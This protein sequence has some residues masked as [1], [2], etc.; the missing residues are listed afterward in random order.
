MDKFLDK[1]IYDKAKKIADDKYKKNSAYKS[2][3]M[4]EKYKELGGKINPK[5]EKKSGTKIWLKEKWKNLTPLALGLETKINNLPACGAK[6]PK[7]G[8]NPSICRPTVKINKETPVLAQS[9]TLNEIKIALKKK[10]KGKRIFWSE[11]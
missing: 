5:A 6:H 11:L 7:Q 10:K 9:Y 3:Y 8:K 4:I 1:N 2:M